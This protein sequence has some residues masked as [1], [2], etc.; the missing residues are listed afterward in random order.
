FL[1]VTNLS[2]G[3]DRSRRSFSGVVAYFTRKPA[4]VNRLSGITMVC[5]A[6]ANV[7]N[8]T[9]GANAMMARR[10]HMILSC[11]SCWTILDQKTRLTLA[12]GR[13][14]AAVAAEAPAHFPTTAGR[15]SPAV[16]WRQDS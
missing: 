14:P 16:C 5:W 3:N 13:G 9:S 1:L 12:E 15:R 10:I 6:N 8:S 4:C 7:T 2:D 11:T